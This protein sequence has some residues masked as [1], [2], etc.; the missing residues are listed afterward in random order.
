MD[1]TSLAFNATP[2]Q[3]RN[4]SKNPSSTTNFTVWYGNH[5]TKRQ[6]L[7]S[8]LH[9]VRSPELHGG[10]GRFRPPAWPRQRAQ[11][12]PVMHE[13]LDFQHLDGNLCVRQLAPSAWGRALQGTPDAS[14]VKR[15]TTMLSA[16]ACPALVVQPAYNTGKGRTIHSIAHSCRCCLAGAGAWC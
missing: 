15:C 9:R 11:S 10:N 3:Q 4:L 7:Q 13:T 12:P 5:E 2:H 8:L 14:G 1:S 16:R 6:S